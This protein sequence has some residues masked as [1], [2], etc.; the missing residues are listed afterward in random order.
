MLNMLSLAFPTHFVET[1]LFELISA[2]VKN[3]C[4]PSLHFQ[5]FSDFVLGCPT[6]FECVPIQ[7]FPYNS[8]NNVSTPKA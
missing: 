8:K 2:K 3:L 6:C 5:E 1:E 4:V 7:L